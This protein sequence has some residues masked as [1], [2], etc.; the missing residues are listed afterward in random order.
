MSGWRRNSVGWVRRSPVIKKVRFRTRLAD[1]MLTIAL[2]K[3]KMLDL[4]LDLFRRAGYALGSRS[5]E[6]RR[7]VF[8]CPDI[9]MTFLFGRPTEV[10]TRVEYGARDERADGS[11]V[12]M[13]A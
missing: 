1:T 11:D 8:P 2:S 3:G 12:M 6:S 10:P 9:G 4:T 13:A 5:I 7:V